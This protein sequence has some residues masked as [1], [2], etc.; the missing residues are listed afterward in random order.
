MTKPVSKSPAKKVLNIIVDVFVILCAVLCVFLVYMNTKYDARYVRTGSMLPE[1]KIG[2]LVWID[3]DAYKNKSPQIG[4]VA[5]YQ[6]PDEDIEIIHRIVGEYKD[7]SYVFK[8]DNNDQSDP[9]EVKKSMI[10]GKEVTHVNFLAPMVR[11]LN[12]IPADGA[13]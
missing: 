13:E 4:D 1:Y 12:H 7:G 9:Y 11:V 3:E 6:S 5:V 10:I 2:A 8:G